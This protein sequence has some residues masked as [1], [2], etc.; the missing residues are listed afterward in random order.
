MTGRE[1]RANAED[2]RLAML[3]ATLINTR[4]PVAVG[5][6]GRRSRAYANAADIEELATSDADRLG[7]RGIRVKST[8]CDGSVCLELADEDWEQRPIDLTGER[9]ALLDRALSLAEPHDDQLSAAVAALDV[10]AGPSVSD[11][12]ISLHPRSPGIGIAEVRSRLHR[13]AGQMARGI[14]TG[15]GYDS[16]D[17]QSLE[18]TLEVWGLGE[19]RGVWYAVG[20]EPGG[21][22]VRAFTV[23][24]MAGP[25][26]DASEPGAYAVPDDFEIAPYLVFGWR[27]GPDPVQAVVRFDATLVAFITTVMPD[28]SL[29]VAED[30]SAEATVEVG[31]LERFV[32][33]VLSFGTHACIVSPQEAVERSTCLLREMIVNNG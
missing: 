6:L 8:V 21:S 1:D 19:Y 26:W 18:R 16:A 25:V 4:G 33:W 17:G 27:L 13:L 29:E 5:S 23:A 9:R 32:C 2:R 14:V 22:T 31:D 20:R 30:G 11:T 12:T 15:F 10:P 7:A 24:A 28:M 3:L